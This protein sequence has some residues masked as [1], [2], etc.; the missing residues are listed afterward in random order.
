MNRKYTN[1]S[2]KNKSEFKK[3]HLPQ[4]FGTVIIV[5]HGVLYKAK[6]IYITNKGVAVCPEE[7]K[8]AYGLLCDIS[9]IGYQCH[10][11]FTVVIK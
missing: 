11:T 4:D 2:H 5:F 10:L 7:V 6:S 9:D 3:P 1:K 8:T